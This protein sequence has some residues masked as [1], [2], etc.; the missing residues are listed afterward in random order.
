MP[1]RRTTPF[2]TAITRDHVT[3]DNRPK[4]KPSELIGYMI[5]FDYKQKKMY[6]ITKANNE[7]NTVYAEGVGWFSVGKIKSCKKKEELV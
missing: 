4:P 7:H 5:D 3:S 2:N 1:L 6:E